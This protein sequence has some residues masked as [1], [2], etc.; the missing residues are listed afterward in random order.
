MTFENLLALIALA[1][2]A[3][4]S[5]GPNNALAANAC[6][7][8]GFRRTFP[9]IAGIGL[10]FPFMIFCVGLGLGQIFETSPMIREIMRW[11]GVVILLWFA[12]KI[13]MSPVTVKQTQRTKPLG[14]FKM[15]AFQWVNPKALAMAISVTSQ[16]AVP[17]A[18][19]KSALIISSVFVGMGFSS[20]STWALFGLAI[21]KFLTSPLRFRIFNITMALLV[22]MSVIAIA[23]PELYR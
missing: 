2:V 14:F 20:A 21:Q 17:E 19:I 6:A 8:F 7:H 1:G 11:G 5:P 12:W 18:P 22:L 3:A 10:G 9:M 15:A 13:A 16:F 23:F 4:F